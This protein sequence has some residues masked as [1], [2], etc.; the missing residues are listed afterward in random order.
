MESIGWAAIGLAGGAVAQCAFCVGVF[1]GAFIHWHASIWY[2]RN[3]D[4]AVARAREKA[5]ADHLAKLEED[6]KRQ[7]ALAGQEL[8]QDRDEAEANFEESLQTLY[9]NDTKLQDEARKARRERDTLR[10]G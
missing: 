3:A 5:Y 10:G 8:P 4:D 2:A 1:F 7:K 6:A 9:P